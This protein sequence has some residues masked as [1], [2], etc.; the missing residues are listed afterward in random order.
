MDDRAER[1]IADVLRAF[2]T[3]R[4]FGEWWDAWP[5][6]TRRELT[7]CLECLAAEHIE[8]DRHAVDV[9]RASGGGDQC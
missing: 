2:G 9:A 8:E 3:V 6:A 7:I 5:E 4:G 1:L